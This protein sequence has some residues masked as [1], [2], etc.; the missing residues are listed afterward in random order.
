[1]TPKYEEPLHWLEVPSLSPWSGIC[2]SF[3]SSSSSSLS[4]GSCAAWPKP[5]T[6][7]DTWVATSIPTGLEQGARH[8]GKNLYQTRMRVQNKGGCSSIPPTTS[9]E[10][11]SAGIPPATGCALIKTILRQKMNENFQFYQYS[12]MIECKTN[13]CKEGHVLC[14]RRVKGKAGC[15]PGALLH[16]QCCL[17]APNSSIPCTGGPGRPLESFHSPITSISGLLLS[18]TSVLSSGRCNPHSG[19]TPLPSAGAGEKRG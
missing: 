9:T 15:V 7:M 5:C 17:Y 12:I 11:R 13:P 18:D 3:S 14:S 1:M 19:S 6:L 8:Q 16:L 10:H 2:T 4:D